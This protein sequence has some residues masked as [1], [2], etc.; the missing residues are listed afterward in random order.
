MLA[1]MAGVLLALAGVTFAQE[2]G[3]RPDEAAGQ[4][5]S[6]AKPIVAEEKFSTT[7]HRARIGGATVPYTATAGQLVLRHANGKPR[8][9][10]FFVAYTRDDQRDPSSRPIAFAYNGG[11]GSATIWLHMGTL[12][13]KRVQMADEGFQP[14]PPFRLVDNEHSLIDVS[15]VVA[16]DAVSTG[17]SRAVEGEDPKQFHGVQQDIEAFSEFIRLYIT[18]FDRWASPKYLLGESYGTVRSAGV[19]AHLQGEHGI[20]LNGIILVSSVINFMTLRDAPGNDIHY[21]S[22]LPTYTATAWYHKKLPSDLMGDLD[23]AIDQ[24]RSLAFGDYLLAL[25]KGNR[26]SSLEREEMAARLARFTGLSADY[27]ASANLRVSP[28]RFRKEL[29]RNERLMVG[30]LDSRFTG[31]DADA[32]GERQEFDP[33]NTALQGPY[34]ALF[35]DYVRNELGW[36]SDLQYFTSGD[37]RPWDYNT[38]HRAEYLNLMEPLRT[39]MA[40]N[41][42]LEI[43]VA[44]GYYDMATPFAATEWT[45]DHLGFESTYRE[46]VQMAYYEAGHMMYIHP[47]MLQNFK[48]D[49]AEFIEATR[50][51]T[52]VSLTSP[53]E[54]Q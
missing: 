46:R 21:A 9:N 28:A 31:I 5:S 32:A 34:T 48:N 41:P 29:L 39:S 53:T 22:F 54:P 44:N 7:Q 51:S 36:E 50:T 37:V 6:Q 10:V 47:E 16:I 42:F 40:R 27:V 35:N 14:A 20:E 3:S 49:L 26:L 19:S 2:T 24:S 25:T 4:E 17:F 23:L 38:Q 33:S 11:P 18:K 15:D 12:G 45:F 13:P 43:F 30:R 1:R 8:A 52:P